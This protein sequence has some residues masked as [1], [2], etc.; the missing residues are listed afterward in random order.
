MYDTPSARWSPSIT[1]SASAIA[2]TSF[3]C[4]ND[5]ASMRL[6]PAAT[7]RSISSIFAPVS[8]SAR[9]FCNPSRGLTSTML[10]ASFEVTGRHL[11]R[12]WRGRP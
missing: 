6:A 3:G 10:T 9:S 7:A 12:R 1:A 5:T 8:S 11:G 2:G 4:T